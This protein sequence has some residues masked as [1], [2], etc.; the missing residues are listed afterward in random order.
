M[1][2]IDQ[3]K[4]FSAKF[5]KISEY[6]PR[7]RGLLFERLFYE[8]FEDHG[9]LL[10]RSFKNEDGSQQIDGAVEINHRIFIVEIKWE[11]SKTVAASKLYSFLGKINSKIDGTLGIFISYNELEQN[12]LDSVRSG[13]KQ[14]CIIIHGEEN[15]IPI[16]QGEVS[17]AEYAWYI[18]QQASTRNRITIPISEFKSI[19]KKSLI[20]DKWG[21]VYEALISE[22]SIGDFELK[23]N[24]NYDQINN[25]PEKAIILY[26]ILQEKSKIH[27]K[28]DYLLD[29]IIDHEDDK[30]KLYESLANMLST[31][32][33]IK[34]ADEYI[35]EKIKKLSKLTA[36]EATKIANNVLP[37]LK[38]KEEQWEE[39]NKASLVLDF[40][41]DHLSER[42]KDKLA[43]AYATIYCDNSRK[44][45]FPQKRL[46]N[47]IFS[48]ID[49]KARWDT[50]KDEV[51]DQIERYKADEIVFS[52]SSKKETKE[53]VIRRIKSTFKR[54]F[55]ES[56]P[57]NLN[58]RLE[59]MYEQA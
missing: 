51:A 23:L 21:E 46:A 49:A 34:Y 31:S 9:I 20:N 40:V 47:K 53:Y 57:R 26:P 36:E 54:I 5:K 4:D 1:R 28:F 55:D 35:L 14:N 16:I 39:E 45:K 7:R 32:H 8:I 2:K 50:I 48:N 11:E 29:T 19:P 17:L 37:Y 59:E 38:D 3:M 43:C 12:F 15:I 27:S 18:Y 56:Q 44:D 24:A 58:P 52:D 41:Y 13:V 25:L 22:K 6:A 10:E 33:W 42:Y 30:R